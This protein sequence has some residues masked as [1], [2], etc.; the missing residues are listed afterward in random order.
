MFGRRQLDGLHDV[1]GNDMSMYCTLLAYLRCCCDMLMCACIHT[2]GSTGSQVIC[3]YRGDGMNS[4]HLKLMGDLGQIVPI[5]FDVHDEVSVKRAV[6][7][8]RG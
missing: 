7:H 2:S 3:P 5:P 8:E 4:R 1:L 6:R